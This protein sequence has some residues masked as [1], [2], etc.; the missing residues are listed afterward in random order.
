MYLTFD[1]GSYLPP[2]FFLNGVVDEKTDVY[3]YGVL[4][5]ELITGR[6]ALDKSQKSLVMWVCWILLSVYLQLQY[7]RVSLYM[8]NTRS[9]IEF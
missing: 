2:E 8:I 7:C 6:P 4:V 9:Y 3:A 1:C 5:L